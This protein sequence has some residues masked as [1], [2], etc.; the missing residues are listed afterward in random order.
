MCADPRQHELSVGGRYWT[1]H[2]IPFRANAPSGDGDANDGANPQSGNGARPA[3]K[4]GLYHF[5]WVFPNTFFQYTT[6]DRGF[7]IGSVDVRGV[8]D[9]E[10]RN[11]F[12]VPKSMPDDEVEKLRLQCDQDPV[13]GEDVGICERV[14]VAHEA[15]LVPPGRLLP[16]SEWLLQHFQ[17][18]LVEMMETHL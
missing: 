5:H 6:L 13:V 1:S 17:R 3:A 7:D 14:Q 18:V 15:G 2:T 16:G 12:F 8:N 9:I 4:R 11:F 10:F